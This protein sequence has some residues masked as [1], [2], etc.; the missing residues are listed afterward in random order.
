MLLIFLTACITS[1]FVNS[2]KACNRQVIRPAMF[3]VANEVPFPVIIVPVV[4]DK[5]V[6]TPTE[7]TSGFTLPSLEG[8]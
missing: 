1:I 6:P 3:G 5:A 2:G 8:P 7:A 4:D